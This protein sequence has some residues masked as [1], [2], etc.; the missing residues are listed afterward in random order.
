MDQKSFT[1]E[2]K[3]RIYSAPEGTAF[4]TSDFLDLAEIPAINKALSRMA[5]DGSI[6]RIIRGVYDRPYYSKVIQ[7]YRAPDMTQVAKAISRNYGW[8]IVPYGNTALN[9]LGLSTQVPAVYKYVSDGPYREYAVG[10][11]TLSFKHGAN[12]NISGLSYKTALV[13]QALKALGKNRVTDKTVGILKSRLSPEEQN[14]F[15]KETQH[16]T[17]WIHQIARKVCSM[18]NDA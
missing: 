11:R 3:N 10:N 5:A 7:E 6:R 9:L 4:I 13:A 1:K 12:K 2:I 17:A 14:A 16:T 8:T 18:E 15:L